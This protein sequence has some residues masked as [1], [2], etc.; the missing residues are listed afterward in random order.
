MIKK[1]FLIITVLTV[2]LASS[3]VAFAYTNP[4]FLTNMVSGGDSWVSPQYIKKLDYEYAVVN[5][6][7]GLPHDGAKFRMRQYEGGHAGQLSLVTSYGYN[8]LGYYSG[9][10]VPNRNFR[11]AA[12]YDGSVS[13][14]IA[15]S[16]KWEP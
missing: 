8:Y 1:I 5:V 10:G 11:L 2:T 16:G 7:S 13:G 9:I 3:V 15:V 6:Q 12:S 4:D 14:T